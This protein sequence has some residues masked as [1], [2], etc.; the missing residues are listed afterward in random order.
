MVLVIMNM[1][2]MMKNVFMV[3]DS[4]LKFMILTLRLRTLLLDI[5]VF[6]F[7]LSDTAIKKLKL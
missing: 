5:M 3:R 6:L 7:I 2:G 1:N 4:V